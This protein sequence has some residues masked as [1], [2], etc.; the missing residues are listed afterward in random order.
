L[1][2][3][4]RFLQAQ[5]TTHA[6]TDLAP[7]QCNWDGSPYTAGNAGYYNYD[8]MRVPMNIMADFNLNHVDVA[9]QTAWAAKNAAFWV[10]EGLASYGDTYNLDG[11][12]KSGTHGAGPTA[13]NAMLA[14]ALPPADGK[15]FVQA[16]WDATVPTGTYRYYSGSLYML[17]MLHLSGKF[18]LT[19]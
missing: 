19:F 4:P 14:F 3:L 2:W 9:W 15:P 16:A 8:A 5:K 6:T 7:G 12:G 10:K 13:M 1:R 18:R 17:A 11:S